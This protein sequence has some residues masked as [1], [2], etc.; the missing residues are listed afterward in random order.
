MRSAAIALGLTAADDVPIQA[1]ALTLRHVALQ[2]ES[3]LRA[4]NDV[5][6]YRPPSA[7]RRGRL[8]TITPEGA[9]YDC[10]RGD[11]AGAHG[12]SL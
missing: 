7:R 5:L 12:V 10:I 6:D 1:E 9:P 3:I 2:E 11:G 4:V 8:D